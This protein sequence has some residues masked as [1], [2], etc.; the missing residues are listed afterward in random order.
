MVYIQLPASWWSLLVLVFQTTLATPVQRGSTGKP[1]KQFFFADVET[2]V[3]A[4]AGSKAELPCLVYGIDLTNVV[5]SVLML[6]IA[7]LLLCG[8]A[9]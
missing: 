3:H 2:K 5:V 7:Q 9:E 8:G 1:V 6:A 4:L